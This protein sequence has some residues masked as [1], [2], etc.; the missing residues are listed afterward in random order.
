MDQASP[1]DPLERVYSSIGLSEDMLQSMIAGGCAGI[2]AKTVI[3]PAERVKMA[4]QTT[5]EVFT[6]RGA[7]TKAQS[8]VTKGGFVTLAGH[9]STIV[10]VAPYAGLSYAFHDLAEGELKKIFEVDKLPIYLQ[11]T[12]G[13]FG[14]QL[15]QP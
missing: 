7:L 10:R 5:K 15:P 2:L 3:A 1:L 11:F 8:M 12:A 6:L 14:V 9:S 4:F 13:S